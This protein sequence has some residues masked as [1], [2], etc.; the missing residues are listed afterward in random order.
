MIVDSLTLDGRSEIVFD[1]STTPFLGYAILGIR[2]LWSGVVE[3]GMLIR[4]Y[5]PFQYVQCML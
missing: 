1:V 5:C 2:A 3:L 4:R